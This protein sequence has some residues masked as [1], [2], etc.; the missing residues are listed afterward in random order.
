M[1][2]KWMDNW[3]VLLLSSALE[4]MNDILS[5]Q[6]R[7]KGPKTKSSVP[8]PKIVKFYNSNMGGV[9]LM[10]HRTAAYRL[11]RKSFVRLFYFCIFFDLMD[12]AHL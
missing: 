10:D 5:V 12:I 9:D 4:G 7:E 1:A 2:C 11:D 3:S 8:C 6:R